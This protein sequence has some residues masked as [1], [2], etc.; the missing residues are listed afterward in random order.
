MLIEKEKGDRQSLEKK[1]RKK[2]TLKARNNLGGHEKP[3]NCAFP[4]AIHPQ[5]PAS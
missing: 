3:V 5:H 1:T 4:S 2:K